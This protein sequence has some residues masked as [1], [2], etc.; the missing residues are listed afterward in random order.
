MRQLSL[1]ALLLVAC[2][3]LA[4][5]SGV[6]QNV[7]NTSLP[8]VVTT[9]YYGYG[10]AGT[11]TNTCTVGLGNTDMG[12]GRILAWPITTG[13]NAAGY[14]VKACGVDYHHVDSTT[15]MGCAVY[16]NN[17]TTSPVSGCTTSAGMNITTGWF[18]NTNFSGCTLAASTTYKIAFQLSTVDGYFWRDSSGTDYFFAGTYPTFN[19]SITWSSQTQTPSFYIRVTAN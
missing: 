9:L 14:S 3:L 15:G 11:S 10:C 16:D 1:L 17:S 12:A 19:S 6:Q 18:E 5:P 4:A 7:V 13:A 2:F 8:V